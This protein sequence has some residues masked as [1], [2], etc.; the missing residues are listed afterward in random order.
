M[1]A[2]TKTQAKT[3][4]GAAK[5]AS[6]KASA[7][8][9]S[10]RT[11]SARSGGGAGARNLVIVESPAKASTI[12]RFL[13]R[14][15][16][17]K[18]SMGHVRDLPQRKLGVNTEQDFRPWYEVLDDKRKV[19]GEI[20]E[21]GDRADGIYLATDPDREGE[22]IAW[23]VVEAAGWRSKPVRRV[24]FHSITEEAVKEAFENERAIDMELVNA[25]QA[26]R[27]EDRLVGFK[28]SPLLK[29][30]VGQEIN[31][32]IQSDG[33]DAANVEAGSVLSAG[34]VQSVALR[35]VVERDD[36][37]DA[38]VPVEYWSIKASLATS[39][40]A[41]FGA[42]LNRRAGEPDEIELPDEAS[43]NAVLADLDGAVYRV[44]SVTRRQ[45]NRRPAA[46][47][48][49]ST[50][51]QEA[52]RRLGF[53]ATKTMSVAQQLYEGVAVGAEGRQGLIT[54]MRTD[55]PQVAP[56]AI[57][58][59][60]RY[61]EERWGKEYLPKTARR[62]AARSAVAQEAHE[63]IRPTAIRRAPESIR[64]HL[65]TDQARLYELIWN[66][67]VA[68]QMADAVLDSTRVDV[69]AGA[70]GKP[71]Y[72]FRATG[73]VVRFAGFRALYA[74]QRDES[75]SADA[76]DEGGDQRALPSL[77][78]GQPLDCRG[79]EP[80]QH[81]TQPPPRFTEASLVRTLEEHGIGR[82]STYAATINTIVQR[83]YVDR[84][85]RTLRSTSL[86]KLVCRQLVA[87]FPDIMDAR[88]T[89]RME[90]RLD[91]VAAGKE[92]WVELL[93]GFYGPFSADLDKAR[94]A[95][96]EAAE[97]AA[98]GPAAEPC[99]VCGR[100]MLV[101]MGRYGPFLACSGYP[102]CKNS[103]DIPRAGEEPDE[104]GE[105]ATDEVCGVCGK[106]MAVRRGRFGPFL[107]C[108][109][110]P[111]CKNRKNIRKESGVACPKCDGSLVERRSKRG[112]FYGCSNYPT[113]SFL[114]N[115]PPL[116]QPCPE[117]D[118]LLVEAAKGQARCVNCVWKGPVPA[119]EPAG[120][121]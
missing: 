43:A 4:S 113:C 65:S 27:I 31:R 33:L 89:K 88:F 94:K 18:A 70:P 7:P 26:R 83:K 53:S 108:T 59:T 73:S 95:I 66:R 48:I 105:G 119:D 68:S 112:P 51:Q 84:E 20:K 90:E 9:R 72:L 91:E 118:G 101:K 36:A 24:V 109:G 1:A 85:R 87:H 75:E 17:V 120:V 96:K 98:S 40:G 11:A 23:H 67:M 97:D 115:R 10:P 30:L 76:E 41:S 15:Y 121:A 28:L 69:D 8:A 107:S 71:A 63:A 81:F 102:E 58:E 45:V 104:E 86:G 99:G 56:S 14:D 106:P 21:A 32:R 38:F 46:P 2:K 50:L 47:F 54:Y 80:A 78:D 92:E 77:D 44:A 25:Q 93:R 12:G 52:S 117:C 110:Y 3:K 39:E 55:S 5:P 79:L 111:E 103:K 19:V 22:A 74:E 16:A 60:R 61:I 57:A 37:I 13:G 42:G 6:R 82:P 34:R 35:L 100:P 49:T 62:Y 64:Q 114:V 29:P 116:R